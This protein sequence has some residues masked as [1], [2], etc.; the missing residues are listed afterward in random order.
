MDTL[1]NPNYIVAHV[2]L[3]VYVFL[4]GRFARLFVYERS[5]PPLVL[6]P[7]CHCYIALAHIAYGGLG[8]HTCESCPEAVGKRAVSRFSFNVS[9]V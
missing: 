2:L 1:C 8:G 4:A 7:P 5:F 9:Q 6:S 3:Y